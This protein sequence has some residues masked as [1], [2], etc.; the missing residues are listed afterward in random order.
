MMWSIIRV[1]DVRYR[2]DIDDAGRGVTHDDASIAILMANMVMVMVRVI[3]AMMMQRGRVRVRVLVRVA[4]DEGSIRHCGQI[5]PNGQSIR[6]RHRHSSIQIRIRNRIH[7][8]IRQRN[9]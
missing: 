6:H 7:Q 5:I 4:G 1:A 2:I 9:G 3:M 8:S